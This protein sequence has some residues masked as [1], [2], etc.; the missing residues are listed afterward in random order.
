MVKDEQPRVQIQELAAHLKIPKHFLG[1]IMQQLAMEG[2]IDSVKGPFGGFSINKKT[3]DTPLLKLI[4]LT[5]GLQQFKECVLRLKKCNAA[6]PCAMHNKIERNR[7]ELAMIF[8]NTTI[9]DLIKS[10]VENFVEY[11]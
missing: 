2:V 11:I 8:T 9:G 1:K 5:D 6:K 7:R 10:D 3:I 4:E